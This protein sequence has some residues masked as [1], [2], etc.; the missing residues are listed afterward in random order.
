MRLSEINKAKKKASG[1][2]LDDLV[3]DLTRDS[4]MFHKPGTRPKGAQASVQHLANNN[5][6]KSA[7]Q[8]ATETVGVHHTPPPQPPKKG[9]R[10]LLPAAVAAGA[11]GGGAYLYKRKRVEKSLS[12][13]HRQMAYSMMRSI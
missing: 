13:A 4:Q 5:P 3:D 7:Q 11:A 10:W 2:S 1:K 6:G 12:Y 8:I 9:G